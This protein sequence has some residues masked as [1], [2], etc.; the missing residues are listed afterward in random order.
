[1]NTNFDSTRLKLKHIA[2]KHFDNA[3]QKEHLIILRGLLYFSQN[4]GKVYEKLLE[5]KKGFV[6]TI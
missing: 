4:I 3:K 2:V 5:T 6:V 1:M